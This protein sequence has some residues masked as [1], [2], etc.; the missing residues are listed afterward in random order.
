MPFAWQQHSTGERPSRRAD[1]YRQEFADRAALLARLHFTKKEARAR[2]IENLGWDYEVGSN[3][4]PITAKDI[5]AIV[6]AA[7]KRGN[8]SG[9]LSN[10]L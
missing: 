3:K 4:A 2:L 8:A 9:D 6:D 7:Y 1:I 10:A 5:D